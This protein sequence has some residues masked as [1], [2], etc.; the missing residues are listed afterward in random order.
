[1]IYFGPRIDPCLD[2]MSVI[3]VTI[4]RWQNRTISD[5]GIGCQTWTR[6]ASK[7]ASTVMVRSMRAG[8]LSFASSLSVARVFGVR[9]VDANGNQ[10]PVR[11]M[12]NGTESHSQC[13]SLVDMLVGWRFDEVLLR[14]PDTWDSLSKHSVET[15]NWDQILRSSLVSE[16]CHKRRRRFVLWTWRSWYCKICLLSEWWMLDKPKRWERCTEPQTIMTLLV[17]SCA[18]AR[19]TFSRQERT[20]EPECIETATVSDVILAPTNQK[21]C[22]SS[23]RSSWP[24][25]YLLLLKEISFASIFL[26]INITL[27]TG[28]L[29]L[30]V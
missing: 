7:N 10:R 14:L 1:M 29:R 15:Q 23:Q 17:S 30:V 4:Y 9:P 20:W 28:S 27:P 24:S 21:S 2:T 25:L 19:E 22:I 8:S 5:H 18:L 11:Q 16:A 12:E 13:P 3:L 6:S 26:V